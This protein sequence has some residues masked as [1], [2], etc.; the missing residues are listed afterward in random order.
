MK[1]SLIC[2]A[3]TETTLGKNLNTILKYRN[4]IDMVELR[5]D[6]LDKAELPFLHKFPRMTDLPIILTIRK[7]TDGGKFV[8]DERQ[9]R[10]LLGNGIQGNYSY[11][12]LEEDFTDNDFS[13]RIKKKG[14]KIIR[15]FHDFSGV[16]HD[17]S[18]RIKALAKSPGELPKAAVMPQSTS[19]VYRLLQCYKE[20]D[21]MDKILLG[22]GTFGFP[23]RILCS[24]LGSYLTY[25]SAP[26]AS[27]APGHIDPVTLTDLYRF[28]EISPKTFVYGI[29][30]NPVMHTFSPCIHNPGFARIGLDAVYL[31]FH[32]DSIKDF[33]EVAEF[34]D[35]RGFSVTIPHKENIIQFLDKKD[36]SV[37]QVAA[38]NTVV[39]EESTHKPARYCGVNTDG[40]GFVEALKERLNKT[41]LDGLKVTTIGA[42]GA[43]KAI[44]FALVSEGAEVLIINRTVHRAEKL[45]DS[46]HCAWAG[47]DDDGLLKMQDYSDIIVQTTS[48]GMEPNSNM[49]PVPGYTFKGHETVYDIVY[50]PEMTLLL[51]RA[52]K[53]GCS[54]ILGKE[55]LLGQAFVQ[56]RLFTGKEYPDKAGVRIL[57]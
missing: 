30:G 5:A 55:M 21:H 44:V 49:D 39:K 1:K 3:V 47:L 11:I 40:I 6:F 37:T 7:K 24:S 14:V 50:K 17:L 23:T 9:R 12:D 10:Q 26:G 56:F 2:L 4:S 42:G 32:V 45:A 52:Q 22:M 43:A 46:F 34:L 48:L 51:K 35:I 57:L 31:P 8:S 38:C 54:I 29:I 25:C 18:R 15:S 20:C 19:E 41:S 36:Q 33:M 53:A 27:A 13:K 16:P 28:R